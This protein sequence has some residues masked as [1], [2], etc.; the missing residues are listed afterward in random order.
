MNNHIVNNLANNHVNN[1]T[2]NIPLHNSPHTTH[3][4]KS[5][6]SIFKDMLNKII[7]KLKTL[8]Q[9]SDERKLYEERYLNVK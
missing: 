7:S 8:G 1:L 4:K 5:D 2:G 3:L 9:S 6:F